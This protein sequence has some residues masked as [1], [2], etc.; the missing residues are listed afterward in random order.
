MALQFHGF[1]EGLSANSLLLLIDNSP[2]V[3]L[4]DICNAYNNN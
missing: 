3:I 4:V 1:M 2:I